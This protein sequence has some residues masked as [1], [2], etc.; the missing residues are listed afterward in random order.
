MTTSVLPG[1]SANKQPASGAKAMNEDEE[2]SSIISGMTTQDKLAQ[3]MIVS[4]APGDENAKAVTG[5]SGDYADMIQKYDFGGIILYADNMTDIAQTVTRIHD[6]QEAAGS[7]ACG[8][9]MLM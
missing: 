3:M 8:T 5:I 7:S 9:P 2:I 6:C 4:F 1:C